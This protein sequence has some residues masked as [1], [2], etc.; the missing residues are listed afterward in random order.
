MNINVKLMKI[1][2]SVLDQTL[3]PTHWDEY[4]GQKHIKDNVKILLRAAE[5]RGHIPRTHSFLW[6]AGFRENYLGTFDCQR[7]WQANE[8][9]FRTS[10]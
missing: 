6:T 4:I 2:E 7:N 8:N 9:N 1:E 3:R 5:E 10:H